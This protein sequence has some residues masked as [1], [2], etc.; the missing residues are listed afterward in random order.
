MKKLKASRR[1]WAIKWFSDSSLDG[2]LQHFIGNGSKSIWIFN[3]RK[4]A[5]DH[6]KERYGYIANRPDLRAQPHGWKMPCAV[7]VTVTVSE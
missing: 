1:A 5:R 4:N 7:R 2:P 3:S 6:I